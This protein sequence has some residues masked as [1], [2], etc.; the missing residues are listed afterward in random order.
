[1]KLYKVFKK[2]LKSNHGD[3]KWKLNKWQ[4][5]KGKLEMCRSGFHCSKKII[6]AMQYTS[7]EII[8]QVEVKGKHLKHTDKQV[9]EQMCIVKTWKWTKD[10][11]V[12][13]AIFTAELVLPNF[14]KVY[15][16]D[17]RPKKAIEAAKRWLRKKSETA[18]NAAVSAAKG[19]RNAAARAS[20]S[21]WKTVGSTAWSAVNAAEIA[22]NAAES[23]AENVVWGARNMAMSAAKNGVV[24][25]VS[26]IKIMNKFEKFILERLSKKLKRNK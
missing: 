25:N 7:A 23:A 19:A 26:R 6:D 11:S 13:L 15:P 21:A 2:N 14:E 20:A 3:I 4:T 5:H 10:D 12:S 17:K 24:K 18:R 16:N 22:A 8:A 1:M 9:W